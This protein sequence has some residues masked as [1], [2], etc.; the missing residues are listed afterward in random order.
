MVLI[1]TRAYFSIHLLTGAALFARAAAAQEKAYDGNFREPLCFDHRA[2]VLGAIIMAAS[3]LEAAINEFHSDAGEA[4]GA[5]IAVLTP[6]ERSLLADMWERG[7]PRTSRYPILDKFDIALALLRK[8]G[9]DR[10]HNTYRD[11]KHVVELRNEF[12]HYEPSWQTHDAMVAPSGADPHR[13]EK[14]LRGRFPDNPITGDGNPYYPDKL[15]GHG[16]ASWAVQAV[17]SFLDRFY[18]VVGVEPTYERY[19][20]WLTTE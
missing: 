15:L 4:D 13:F 3:A 20:R 2:H 6:A 8:G 17:T 1:K 11:V 12:V 14:A 7:I 16:C 10:S 5:R 19:R 9:L 18:G